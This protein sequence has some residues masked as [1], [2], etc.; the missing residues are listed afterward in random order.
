MDW[1][2]QH[3]Q[4]YK[5]NEIPTKIPITFVL[6]RRYNDSPENTRIAKAILKIKKHK[7]EGIKIPY[8]KTHYKA[9][10]IKKVWCWY[11]NRKRDQWNRLETTEENLDLYS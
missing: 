7:I 6:E 1:Q 8:F 5:T 3:Q 4:D 11:R 10:V 2:N 9:V